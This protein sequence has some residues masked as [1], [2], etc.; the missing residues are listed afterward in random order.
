[1]KSLIILVFSLA[2][3]AFAHSSEDHQ[4]SQRQIVIAI[5]TQ[6]TSASNKDTFT[7]D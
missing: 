3:S 7:F 2:F 5:L 4:S 1:M 6:P